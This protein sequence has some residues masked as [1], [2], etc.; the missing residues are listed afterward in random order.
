MSKSAIGVWFTIKPLVVLSRVDAM[1]SVNDGMFQITDEALCVM[2]SPVNL[3]SQEHNHVNMLRVLVA[4]G[5]STT[6]NVC[7]VLLVYLC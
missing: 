5:T 7:N 4:Y 6:C 2:P 1:A 3:G